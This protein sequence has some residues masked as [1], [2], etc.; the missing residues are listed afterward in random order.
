MS[1]SAL[2]ASSVPSEL[3]RPVY[4]APRLPS[5]SKLVV[6]GDLQKAL[7]AAAPWSA[8]FAD[9][10][11]S[12]DAPPGTAPADSCTTRMKMLWDDEFLYVGAV[13]S[14]SDSLPVI[15]EF[16]ERNSPIY[17]RDSDFEVFIDADHSCHNYKELE[18]NAR[19]VVWNLLLTR[20]YSDGG[21]EHSGRVAKP[22][23][24]N[25]YEVAS[26]RTAVRFLDGELGGSAPARWAVEIALAH[27]DTIA[28]NP[29][30]RTPAPGQ[31]W[32]INFSRVEKQGEVNWTWA[33]QVVW[34][35]RKRTFEGKV[36]MHLPDAWGYVEFAEPSEG[37]LGQMDA[38]AAATVAAEPANAV[39]AAAMIIYYAQHAYRET[40]G[41]FSPSI[42]GLQADRLVDEASIARLSVEIEAREGGFVATATD[43]ETGVRAIVSQDRYVELQLQS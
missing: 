11:G 2:T 1:S 15:A 39:R 21:G 24:E 37:A 43:P 19:N 33:P 29:G 38:A 20:P 34:E 36:N 7:W 14:Y 35:P 18:V 22:G 41:N 31:R 10:R 12:R 5:G 26:Q 6:D 32:R 9:I 40:A 28:R 23:D 30:A 25:F 3:S 8:E 27:A 4:R 16:T 42:E 13:L 17:Q